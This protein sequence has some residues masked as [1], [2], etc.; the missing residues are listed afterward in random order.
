VTTPEVDPAEPVDPTG[1]TITEQSGTDLRGNPIQVTWSIVRDSD[2]VGLGAYATKEDVRLVIAND[3][4]QREA[5]EEARTASEK[6][7]S[8]RTKSK[9]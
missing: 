6:K 8:G 9:A 3:R 7:T 1:Y 2:G 4:A 5:E